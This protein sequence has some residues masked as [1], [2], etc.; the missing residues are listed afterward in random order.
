[1]KKS[2]LVWSQLEGEQIGIYKGI[3]RYSVENHPKWGIVCWRWKHKNNKSEKF[4]ALRFTSFDKAMKWAEKQHQE[5][6]S[7]K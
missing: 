5:S 3:I 7:R 6:T 2:P 1:M 4:T